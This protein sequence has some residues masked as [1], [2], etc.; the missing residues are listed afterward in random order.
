MFKKGFIVLFSTPG[1]VLDVSLHSRPVLANNK[2]A[3]REAF[4]REQDQPA[5]I[6]AVLSMED[7][8]VLRRQVLSLAEDSG[9]SL[10]IG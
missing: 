4:E 9:A 6:V 7:I 10:S 2:Q 8:S 5:A 3:A 1:Q